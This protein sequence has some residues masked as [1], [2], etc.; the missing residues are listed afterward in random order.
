MMK[1]HYMFVVTTTRHRTRYQN[2]ATGEVVSVKRV[3]GDRPAPTPPVEPGR[4]R[5]FRRGRLNAE[6]EVHGI[7][8]GQ[9]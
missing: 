8:G 4:R 9:R 6:A 3:P 7:E 1:N 5:R 2:I